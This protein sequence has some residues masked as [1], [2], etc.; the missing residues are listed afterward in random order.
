MSRRLDFYPDNDDFYGDA[1]E[2]VLPWYGGDVPGAET[3]YSLD[4]LAEQNEPVRM[5]RPDRQPSD[6]LTVVP[7]RLGSVSRRRTDANGFWTCLPIK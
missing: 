1:M 5:T 4:V 3:G 6:L 7:V 2:H